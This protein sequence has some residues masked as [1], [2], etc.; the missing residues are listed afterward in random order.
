MPVATLVHRLAAIE[1]LVDESIQELDNIIAVRH[2]ECA[3]RT[4][5]ILD[6]NNY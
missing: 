3:A 2:C 4:E 1:K 6:V 5:V